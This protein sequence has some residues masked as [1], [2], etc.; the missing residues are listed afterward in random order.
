MRATMEDFLPH[1]IFLDLW[2]LSVLQQTHTVQ[3]VPTLPSAVTILN[4]EDEKE[5]RL[6]S[7]SKTFL[8][9]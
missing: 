5:G 9:I 6:P 3:I 4:N 7:L 1:V 2:A 8:F